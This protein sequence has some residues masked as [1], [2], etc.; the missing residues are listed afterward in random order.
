MKMNEKIAILTDSGSD[1]PLHL[2]KEFNIFVLPLQ[3]NFK[4]GSYRDGIDIDAE[5][6]YRRLPTEVP[7]TSLPTGEDIEA[8]FQS[9]VEQ[10][11][12]H[13]L[14]I[15][16]SS[17]LSGTHNLIRLSAADAPLPMVVLD[18]KN[19]GIGSG[20]SVIK[21][22]ELVRSGLPFE[23]VIKLTE[24]AV[25]STKTFFVLSTLE[26]LQKGGRIGK[27]QAI[28]G[29]T[30]D[31]K[32]IISC[33]EDGI[34]VTVAKARGRKQSLRKCVELAVEYAQQ[35]TNLR[36]ALGHADAI[37]ECTALKDDLV[38]ALQLT[39]EVYIG[40]ISSALG[41]H[42]GPGLIGVCVQKN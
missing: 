4:D 18:T 13:I 42:V 41:V 32:P 21:A 40:P 27:V 19:I 39:N 35:E 5:T 17:G 14:G 2:V 22:A 33:N 10:G 3:V 1:V 30:F 20:I 15:T 11:Y 29:T 23:E 28:M 24:K 34:Y 38:A 9:I 8:C 25:L 37:E 31:I 6:V 7:T 12:T 16:I 26:Y 36:V